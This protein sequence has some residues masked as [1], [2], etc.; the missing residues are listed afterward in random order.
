MINQF[1]QQSP[2]EIIFGLGVIEQLPNLIE[3]F[4]D[5]ILLITGKKS[6][7]QNLSLQR[8]LD[9][10]SKRFKVVTEKITNE[11]SPD[12]I[13]FIVEIHK[14]FMPNLVIAIGG[15]SVLDA[16]KAISGMLM[17]SHPIE[18]YLEGVGTM[19]PTGKKVPFIAVPTTAGTGSECTKNAVI[20][21]IGKKGFKKSLR[22]NCYL[23]NIALVDPALTMSCSNVQTAASGLDATTQLLEAFLSTNS[24]PMTNALALDGLGRVLSNLE[25]A[26]EKNTINSKIEVSYASMISGLCIANAGLGLVHGFAQ[27]LGSIA[28]IPHGIVCANLIGIV[29]KLT[30]HKLK[31]ANNFET[32]ERYKQVANLIFPE[33][34]DSDKIELLINKLLELPKKF[35]LPSFIEFGLDPKDFDL[36]IGLTSHKNH[37]IE[38]TNNELKEILSFAL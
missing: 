24:S 32:L 35:K 22:H 15:G 5:R 29:N 28:A 9:E 1:K 4:G 13:N 14:A 31:D 8:V 34:N 30:V 11:P 20:T 10:F 6:I 2:T 12:Q 27:P 23:P 21:K 38:F 7:N 17:E 3:Q 19:L 33:V 18:N 16:G 25:E 36:L 37:P 26:V